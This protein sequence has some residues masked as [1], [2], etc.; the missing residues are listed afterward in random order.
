MAIG[1]GVNR[2]LRRSWRGRPRMVRLGRVRRGIA[3]G[4]LRVSFGAASS[5][6]W[7]SREQSLGIYSINAANAS[8]SSSTIPSELSFSRMFRT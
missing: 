6:S 2:G 7:E 4:P 3:R 1:C 5:F 8:T